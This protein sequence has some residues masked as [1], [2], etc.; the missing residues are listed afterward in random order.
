MRVELIHPQELDAGAIADWLALRARLPAF[1][2][3]YFHPRFA[4]IVGQV[5]AD[6]RVLVLEDGGRRVGFWA[7]HRRPDGF[8]R[9]IG[10]PLADEN[11]P[12]LD[13]NASIDLADALRKA[14]LGAA[15]F[16]GLPCPPQAVAPFVCEVGESARI[17]LAS[18]GAST[19]AALRE[20]HSTH[21]KNMR[22]KERKA[23]DAYRDIS[24]DPA[25]ANQDTLDTLIGWKRAQFQRTGLYDVFAPA[26]TRALI[27]ALAQEK[28]PAFRGVLT[29]LRLGDR[30]AA[31]EFALQSGGHLH[32]WITAYDADFSA[33]S[34]GHLLQL[35]MIEG[36]DAAGVGVIDIGVGASHYKRFYA[37]AAEPLAQGMV[38]ARGFVGALH[39]ARSQLWRAAEANPVGAI[40][41]AFGRLRRRSEIIMSADQTFQGRVGGMLQAVRDA[42][43][44]PSEAAG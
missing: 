37:N 36:A 43:V 17:D 18:G 30:L 41:G 44:K 27:A 25:C 38:A 7:L 20:A 5:R 12:L 6:A 8:A 15:A 28:S 26:W 23:L 34:P 22:R 9:P 24:Y 32:S 42:S 31:A 33:L 3:P 13:P 1:G 39:G 21:F 11:G 19:L 35:R 40:G 14:R 29:T 4:Q 2:S 16:T 10:Q